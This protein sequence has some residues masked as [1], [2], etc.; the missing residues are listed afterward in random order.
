M[1]FGPGNRE[2]AKIIKCLMAFA[3]TQDGGSI[4]V[5]VSEASGKFVSSGLTDRQADSFD[6]SKV[7]DFAR[8]HCSELPDFVVHR[9]EI[10]GNLLVLIEIQGFREDPVLAT[11]DVFD[12]DEK[13]IL[14]EGALYIRT[15]DAKCE[16]PKTA[17][18]LRRLIRLAVRK[19]GDVLIG[20]I[21]DLVGS[22][23]AVLD[24]PSGGPVSEELSTAEDF[25]EENSV[26]A[27]ESFWQFAIW[28]ADYEAE[29]WT[30]DELRDA[31]RDAEV[32]LRGWYVPHIDNE[33]DKNFEHGI[34]SW[35]NWGQYFEA[36]RL[37][38]SGLAVWRRRMWEDFAIDKETLSYVSAIWSVTEQVL[39]MSRYAEVLFEDG[40]VVLDWTISGLKGRHLRSDS[41]SGVHLSLD[42]MTEAIQLRRSLSTSVADLRGGW[43]E[44]ATDWTQELMELFQFQVGRDVLHDWQTKLI[45]RKF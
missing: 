41:G 45:E 11:K 39:F 29:R 44:I 31:R 28:P 33:N 14:R 2:K 36:H 27:T 13:Q 18:E 32:A 8:R 10:D 9:S 3:N 1:S 5:G 20:Q 23:V 26:P 19:Q 4:L 16:E 22:Q 43:R 42:Y 30:R 34:Q 7:G 24:S 38:K 37:Y 17:A 25:C 6:Q 35:T 15:D 21:R 12:D 40:D